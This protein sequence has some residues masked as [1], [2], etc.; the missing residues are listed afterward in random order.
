MKVAV[1]NELY[2]TKRQG[3]EQE[4]IHEL[5]QRLRA[6]GWLVDLYAYCSQPGYKRIKTNVPLFLRLA[7]FFRDIFVL[8]WIGRRFLP[9]ID[10][11]YD[12]II[13]S[14][15]SWFSFGRLHTP[16]LLI[17]HA[18]RTQKSEKLSR[19]NEYRLLFNPLTRW[20]LY[21]AEN[22]GLQEVTKVVVI[23]ETMKKYLVRRFAL[24]DNKITVIPNAVDT[25]KFQPTG[26]KQSDIV[27]FVGR[28]TNNKGIDILLEAAPQIKAQVIVV[29]RLASPEVMAQGRKKGVKFILNTPH[30]QMPALYQGA[31]VFVL[32]SLDEEQPLTI[33]EAMA[34]GL[35]VVTT[36]AGSGSL[37]RDGANGYIIPEQDPKAL[38]T[39]VNKLLARGGLQDKINT[40]NQKLITANHTWDKILPKYTTVLK[41][42][43]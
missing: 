20:L 4:A 13:G 24:S 7:P 22:K 21:L 27:L 11:K 32:P 8:P 43:K 10:E 26:Q 16:F 2:G 5:A 23:R 30:D 29:T 17:Y 1:I 19:Q 38:V 33:I 3:G 40:N 12:V 6:Q 15:A 18:V 37:I 36:K 25:E 28:S 31:K 39:A 42:I 35:P 9:K 34:C 41:Q 14:T